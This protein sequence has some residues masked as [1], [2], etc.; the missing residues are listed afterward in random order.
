MF[1][2]DIAIDTKRK[3]KTTEKEN[4]E[5]W[6]KNKLGHENKNVVSSIPNKNR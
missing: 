5:K 6:Y 4:K 1:Q 3:K 2:N